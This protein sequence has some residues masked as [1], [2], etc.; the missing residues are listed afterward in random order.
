MMFRLIP[1]AIVFSLLS[2]SSH[3]GFYSGNEILDRCSSDERSDNHF[4]KDAFCMGYL[5]GVYDSYEGITICPGN[6]ANNI[7]IGQL[8]LIS[9]KYMRE[10]PEKLN[11]SAIDLIEQGL[12]Q[13]FP[14]K[15]K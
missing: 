4:Q 14:C 10:H 2:F 5:V 9:V 7:T 11:G 6:N 1:L 13:A 8:Q 12:N 3:A 15:N